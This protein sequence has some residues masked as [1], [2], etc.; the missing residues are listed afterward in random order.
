MER[1]ESSPSQFVVGS[2]Q[3]AFPRLNPL[4]RSRWSRIET[5]ILP[6]KY[7]SILEVQPAGYAEQHP[8]SSSSQGGSMSQVMHG[9]V[10]NVSIS[11]TSPA[12]GH[13]Q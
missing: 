8:A 12:D 7:L 5:T 3:Q 13:I 6:P 11:L 2:N 10:V 9:S 1:M 4:V